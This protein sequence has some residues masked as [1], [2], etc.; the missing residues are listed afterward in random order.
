MEHVTRL[1]PLPPRATPSGAAAQSRAE[2]RIGVAPCILGAVKDVF[3]ASQSPVRQLIELNIMDVVVDAIRGFQ[4]LGD[5][6]QASVMGAWYTTWW[7][8]AVLDWTD[9][10]VQPLKAMLRKEAGAI[11]YALDHP[12][13]QCRYLNFGTP[14]HPRCN[15]M[16]PGPRL[17]RVDRR[18][19][20][21]GVQRQ[22]R[23]PLLLLHHLLVHGVHGQHGQPSYIR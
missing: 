5:I 2:Q 7:M 4:L 17:P 23:Q 22:R 11:R 16:Y 19:I 14:T 18:G 3:Q 9:P 12:V 13:W 1:A 21:P 15:P 10:Q 8:L 20:L 6:E